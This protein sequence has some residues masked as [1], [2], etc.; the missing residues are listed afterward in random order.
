MA[1]L[2]SPDYVRARWAYSELLSLRLGDEYQGPGMSELR[3]RAREKVPFDDLGHGERR[4]LVE[5]LAVV[6]APVLQALDGINWF[7]QEP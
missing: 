7:K 4:L 1:G 5:Q 6:R 2:V 3:Q